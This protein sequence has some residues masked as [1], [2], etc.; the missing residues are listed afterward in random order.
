VLDRTIEMPAP[1]R[2]WIAN[3][4]YVWTAEGWLYFAAVV[5]FPNFAE[6]MSA[7]IAISGLPLYRRQ[8]DLTTN[9]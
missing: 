7:G 8:I 4:T 1:N 2:N 5:D 6:N 3:F 9:N